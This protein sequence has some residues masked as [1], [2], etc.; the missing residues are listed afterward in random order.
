MIV[1][2]LPEN[3]VAVSPPLDDPEGL[4]A[5][6]GA[7][8]WREV[9]A[10]PEAPQERWEW[11]DAGALGVMPPPPPPVPDLSFAQLVIGLVEEAWI[12]EA[13]GDG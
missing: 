3:R 11:T 7:T 13:E 5:A 9:D 10:V 1:F 6:I 12:T 2:R 8:V 4:A